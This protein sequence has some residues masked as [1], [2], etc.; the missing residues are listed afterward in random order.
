MDQPKATRDIVKRAKR[1]RFDGEDR[2]KV[3]YITDQLQNKEREDED[4]R[5]LTGTLTQIV[6]AAQRERDR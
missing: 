2:R 1:M 6:K 3:N 4:V 5:L